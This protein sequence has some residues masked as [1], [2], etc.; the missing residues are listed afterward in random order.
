MSSHWKPL[1]SKLGEDRCVGFM[2]MGRMSGINHY[3]HGISRRY[4][5]LDD[6]GRSYQTVAPNIFQEVTFE[7][8]L[9]DVEAPLR[10]LGAT[11]RT[12]YDQAFVERKVA[13]LGAAGI[14][15][16]TVRVV[17]DEDGAT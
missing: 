13:V 6:E 3:K 11:L 16:L 2:F 14:E 7:K 8:A 4:L 17:P 10:A 9:E 1:E 15:L 5:L 12:P